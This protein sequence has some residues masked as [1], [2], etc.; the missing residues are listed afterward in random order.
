MTW[1]AVMIQNEGNL[2]RVS[3]NNKTLLVTY[4]ADGS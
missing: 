2:I 4:L 1:L 3:D